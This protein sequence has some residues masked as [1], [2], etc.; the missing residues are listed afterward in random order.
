MKQ[1][2]NDYPEKSL[3]IVIEHVFICSNPYIYTTVVSRTIYNLFLLSTTK[4]TEF[5]D[6]RPFYIILCQLMSSCDIPSTTFLGYC[7]SYC[8]FQTCCSLIFLLSYFLTYLLTLARFVEGPLPLKI[9]SRL[10]S[11]C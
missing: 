3:N 5:F 2:T 6:L 11:V 10:I 4:H 9:T 8:W 1:C 7:R